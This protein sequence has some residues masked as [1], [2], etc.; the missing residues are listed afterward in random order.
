MYAKP[1]GQIIK[2]HNIKYR[3]NAN[4]IQVYMT[5]KQCYKCDNIS[6]SIETYIGDKGVCINSNMLKLNKDKTEFIV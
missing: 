3:C 1:A 6:S 5:L 4:D 2:W